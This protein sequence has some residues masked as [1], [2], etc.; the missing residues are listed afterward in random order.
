MY[1]LKPSDERP[2][3]ISYFAIMFE[4]WSSDWANKSKFLNLESAVSARPARADVN[5]N[6]NVCKSLMTSR[7]P[8][9]PQYR[10]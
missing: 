1:F 6:D 9:S 7:R 10:R 8:P 3:N 4:K 5:I 2:I